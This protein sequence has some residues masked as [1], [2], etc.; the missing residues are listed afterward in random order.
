MKLTE[1]EM[2]ND[3]PPVSWSPMNWRDTPSSVSGC[4]SKLG[5][6][7]TGERTSRPSSCSTKKKARP[8]WRVPRWCQNWFSRC[9][10]R[11]AP[12][13]QIGTGPDEI[14][15]AASRYRPARPADYT[16]YQPRLCDRLSK[17]GYA[18]MIAS[19]RPERRCCTPANRERGRESVAYRGSGYRWREPAGIDLAH[20][21]GRSPEVTDCRSNR[22]QKRAGLPLSSPHHWL[23]SDVVNDPR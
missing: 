17:N 12:L 10:R 3:S 18:R 22:G 19:F 15:S 23:I 21:V 14:P 4:G 11:I 9:H 16:R 7:T 8:W 20:F 1:S 2:T 13:A 5:V 6:T